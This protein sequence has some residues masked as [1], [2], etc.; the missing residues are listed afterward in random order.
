MLSTGDTHRFE[1]QLIV[2]AVV[3]KELR[4]DF[5]LGRPPDAHIFLNSMQRV[6]HVITITVY[7]NEVVFTSVLGLTSPMAFPQHS[8]PS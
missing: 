3:W 5:L 8:P 6:I 1:R 2:Q 4:F 7:F